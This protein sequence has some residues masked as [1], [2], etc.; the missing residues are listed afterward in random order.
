MLSD[1]LHHF[2]RQGAVALGID[3]GHVR[4]GVAQDDLRGLQAELLP[5]LGSAGVPQLVGVPV[6]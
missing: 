3:L 6:G 1:F 5:D 4:L 2:H